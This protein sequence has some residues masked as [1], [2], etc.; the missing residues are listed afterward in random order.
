M[1]AMMV[2]TLTKNGPNN[3]MGNINGKNEIIK[4]IISS[5]TYQSRTS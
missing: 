1:A 4:S 5:F 3:K 2:G